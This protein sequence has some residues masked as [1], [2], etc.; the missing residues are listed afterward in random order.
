M[1]ASFLPLLRECIPTAA[2]EIEA[3]IHSSHTEEY[4]YDYYAVN[5][6][7]DISEDSSKHQFPLCVFFVFLELLHFF[8]SL[9]FV[10]P[11]NLCSWAFFLSQCQS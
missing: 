5:E 11:A 3:D 10:S 9:S 1:L 4:V 6:D 2:E 7:M 8:P